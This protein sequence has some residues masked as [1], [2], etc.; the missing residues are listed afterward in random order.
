[1]GGARGSGVRNRYAGVARSSLGIVAGPDFDTEIKQL[2]ATMSTIEQVLDI[3]AM[4][5]EI[6]DL[7]EQVSAPDLWDDQDNATRVTGRLSGLQG[8]VD[9]FT[10]LSGRLDDLEIMVQLGQEES[11]AGVLTDA[12]SELAK[13]RKTVE[14]LEVRTLLSGE[15]D[16]RDALI[17]VRSGAGGVDAADFTETLMRMYTRWAEQHNYDVEVFDTSYAEEAGLKSAT[18]AIHAPL[19]LRHAL[20]RGRHPPAGPDQPV[21]QPGPA[22][23]QLRR[24][25]GGPAAG[26]DRRD[27]HPRRGRPGRRLPL[28]RP[29]RPVG[30]HHRL[31]GPADPPPDRHRGQLPEREEPAAEQGLARW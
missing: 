18:F 9:R 4:R 5:R 24:G 7:G 13:I 21:R 16:V 20:G 22:P 30:Q 28:L 23:D 26:D 3:P 27:R 14:A 15:Y 17:T 8:E 1:M 19:R 31:G 10:E 2:R 12:E 29:R 6:A 11:D 25:R